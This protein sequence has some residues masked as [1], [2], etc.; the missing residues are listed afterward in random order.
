MFRTRTTTKKDWT[1]RIYR[2]MGKVLR[3]RND[4]E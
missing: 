1:R 3:S 2:T 4:K